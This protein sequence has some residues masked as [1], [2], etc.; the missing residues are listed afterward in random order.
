MKSEEQNSIINSLK[1]ELEKKKMSFEGVLQE[2]EYL[3]NK[4][5]SFNKKQELL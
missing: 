5:E 3:K 2:N 1:E 4:Y